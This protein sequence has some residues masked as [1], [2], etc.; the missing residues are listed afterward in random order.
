LDAAGN[1]VT[2]VEFTITFDPTIVQVVDADATAPGVQVGLGNCFVGKDYFEGRNWVDNKNG[3]IEFAAT[4]YQPAFPITGQCFV[5]S[6]TWQVVVAGWADVQFQRTA[7]VDFDG[8]PIA[9]NSTGGQVGGDTR[10]P[11]CGR[12]RLQGRSDTRLQDTLVILTEEPCLPSTQSTEA[13]PA[14]RQRFSTPIPDLP[15]AYTNNN[16][17][18]TIIPY[19]GH[20]YRCLSVFQHGY[21]SGQ[22]ALPRGGFA[23]AY[24]LGDIRLLGG[25][26]DENDVINIFDL[27][28]IAM[29]FGVTS[30]QSRWSGC[31]VVDINA[32]NKIDIADL[33]ITAGNFGRCGPLST[34]EQPG[35]CACP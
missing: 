6:I 19:D 10:P 24:N 20:D 23:G 14:N 7:L 22:Q 21:L 2:G 12:V 4:L 16:G 11:I 33:S 1:K 34:W 35:T 30:G 5:A 31:R 29:C 9:H 25:D 26:V 28:K 18:F 15:F 17:C 3:Q 8:M 32:D 27:V 13:A